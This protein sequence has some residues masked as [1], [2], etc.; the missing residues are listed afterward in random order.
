MS[1][2]YYFDTQTGLWQFIGTAKPKRT[3]PKSWSKVKLITLP[4]LRSNYNSGIFTLYKAVTTPR[5]LVDH[6]LY[7]FSTYRDGC[8]HEFCGLIT[9]VHRVFSPCSLHGK[10]HVPAHVINS[11]FR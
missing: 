5:T 2:D 6:D 9:Q 8:F 1:N 4:A 3:I 11:Y 10:E 7:L